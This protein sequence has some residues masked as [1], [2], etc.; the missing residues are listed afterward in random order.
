MLLY[1]S[2]QEFVGIYTKYCILLYNYKKV[3]D[4]FISYVLYVR[5]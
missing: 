5:Y 3:L 2:I 4:F 1:I